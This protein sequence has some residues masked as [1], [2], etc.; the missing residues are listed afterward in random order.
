[1]RALTS[2][3]GNTEKQDRSAVV[4]ESSKRPW[5]APHGFLL[6]KLRCKLKSF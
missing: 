1:M 2:K 4:D 5:V 3:Y 6:S